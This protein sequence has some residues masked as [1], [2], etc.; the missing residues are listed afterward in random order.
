MRRSYIYLVLSLISL[1]QCRMIFAQQNCTTIT[2]WNIANLGGSKHDT[3]IAFIAQV[4]KKSD[5]VCI[6]EVSTGPAGAKAVGKIVDELN[7][8]G[9]KWDYK[10][11]DPTTGN[12]SERY[13][14]LWKTNKV[15]LVG[16]P[17]LEKRLQDSV[18]REP[19]LAVFS[20][21]K[22]TFLLATFHAVP[23]EKDPA[24]EISKIHMLDSWYENYHLL[25]M[26]DFNLSSKKDAFHSMNERKL[27]NSICD[28]KTSIKME[29]NPKTG[30]HLANEYDNIFFE[31]DEINLSSS[32]VIDFTMGLKCDLKTA[33]KVSDHIPVWGC[34]EVLTRIHRIK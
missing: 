2:T 15:K 5:I 32:G 4:I 13:A 19:F 27:K 16:K 23:K 17:W 18:N 28:Q 25:I 29:P 26:G 33:R 30:E 11:S 12:G 21:N 22:D 1:L 20:N 3:I 9:N 14:M 34:Y 8:S 6:Q 10:I 24:R 7:R 31:E